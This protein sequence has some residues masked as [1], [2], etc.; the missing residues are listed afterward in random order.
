MALDYKLH[1][2]TEEKI[3]TLVD[4]K[5]DIKRREDNLVKQIKQLQK[6]SKQLLIDQKEWEIQKSLEAR[7]L[8]KELK[9]AREVQEYNEKDLE[10]IKI[11]KKALSEDKVVLQKA[12]DELKIKSETIRRNLRR[13]KDKDDILH[14]REQTLKEQ[15]L[16]LSGMKLSAKR[17]L[18]SATG[19]INLAKEKDKKA[20]ILLER[21]KQKNSEANGLKISL[22]LER[23]GIE[24]L[25]KD[26]KEQRQWVGARRAELDVAAKEVMY[27]R[28]LLT[29]A[30]S[31]ADLNELD[32]KVI[33]KIGW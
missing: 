22:G 31:M 8:Q 11:G 29:K 28:K 25:R 10:L 26:L 27:K 12:E 32:T 1:K 33:Q 9:K 4:Q 24:A 14:N 18:D 13:L 3:D 15:E 16:R 5:L 21:A 6:D 30:Y 23:K 2:A 19:L 20:K 7:Q 17:M